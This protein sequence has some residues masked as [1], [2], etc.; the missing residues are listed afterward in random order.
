M[1]DK[2]VLVSDK[3]VEVQPLIDDKKEITVCVDIGVQTDE[4]CANPVPV[5]MVPRVYDRQG[6]VS[7]PVRRFVGAAV[8][9]HTGNDGRVRQLCG[10]GITHLLPGCA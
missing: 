8:R 4:S 7:A 1:D 2:H 6:Y 9:M 5:P 3:P 10:P